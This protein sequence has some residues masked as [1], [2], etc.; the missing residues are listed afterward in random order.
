MFIETVFRATPDLS[1]VTE[2]VPIPIPLTRIML[3]IT[4]FPLS[5]TFEVEST[6]AEQFCGV[7]V[8]AVIGA[9]YV[10]P[11]ALKLFTLFTN[12]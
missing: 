4:K 8:D 10:P 1:T 12:T 2:Q 6:D 7:L 11:R 5:K 3:Q 9:S